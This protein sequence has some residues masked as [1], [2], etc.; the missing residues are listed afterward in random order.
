MNPWRRFLRA[1]ARVLI[2]LVAGVAATWGAFALWYQLPND[3]ALR[4]VGA[5][6]WAVFGFSV[7]VAL[8]SRHMAQGPST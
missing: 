1:A 3:H 5:A 6:L 7:L 8:W 2:T 4:V